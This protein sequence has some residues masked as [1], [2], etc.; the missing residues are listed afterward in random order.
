[1]IELALLVYLTLGRLTSATTE[2]SLDVHNLNIP[3]PY[4]GEGYGADAEDILLRVS[5]DSG[6]LECFYQDVKPNH[7]LEL[8]IDVIE[9]E[10]RVIPVVQDPS[11]LW[12]GFQFYSPTGALLIERAR[13]REIEHSE[14]SQ[15]GG[16]YQFCL[17]NRQSSF[18]S[19]VVSVEI[20]VYSESGDDRWVTFFSFILFDNG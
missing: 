11:D 16:T 6:R 13:D 17:D 18:G 8:R 3:N 12:I 9:S 10:S 7:N 14:F 2:V 4:V 19:K 5:V 15:D 1:M 20:Y